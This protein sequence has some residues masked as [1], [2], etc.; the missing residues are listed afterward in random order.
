MPVVGD[1]GLGPERKRE[2][3]LQRI[4]PTYGGISG[5]YSG[6]T[7]TPTTASFLGDWRSVDAWM[8][9]ELPIAR[10]RS[11]QIERGN[12]YGQSFKASLTNNVLGASGIKARSNVTHSVAYGDPQSKN[13]APDAAANVIIADAR[14]R[15]EKQ[16]NCT[17]SKK[18]S[19]RELDQLILQRM[20]FDGETILRKRPGFANDFKF[21]WEVIDADYLDHWLNRIEPNGNV[22]RMGIE[23]DR[24]FG[25]PVAY[26]FLTRRPGD[27]LFGRYDPEQYKH[28]R[29]P[30]EEII[31]LFVTEYPGQSRGIP[32]IFSVLVKL[33]MQG[34]YEEAAITNA[35]IGAIKS[36]FFSK[37]YP[38]GYEGPPNG[39]P[40]GDDGI[41]VEYPQAGEW[42]ELPYG[43]KP[44]A[45]DPKYP[46]AEFGKFNEAMLLGI[47]S[48]LK[49][50]YAG[51]SGDYSQSNFSSSRMG[52]NEERE[53]WKILQSFLIEK[54]KEPEWDEWLYRSILSRQINLPLNKFDKFNEPKFTGRRWGYINPQQDLAA[55]Q[56]Q[57]A[58]GSTSITAI[59]EEGGGDRDELLAQIKQDKLD[60]G[61]LGIN[62]F[63]LPN[64]PLKPES[65]KELDTEKKPAPDNKPPPP[66]E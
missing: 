55:Q 4:A 35:R 61:A 5:T 14:Y 10:A 15:F 31:H 2:V 23:Q 29:V 66:E 36:G 27:Y 62:P 17:T 8:A 3:F 42:T 54:W 40:G 58:I 9:A 63:V 43:V 13:G 7:T 19:G 45:W 16:E 44:V 59:I 24:E 56:I 38:T 41:M 53:Y 50:S 30:A 46:D 25:F 34:A 11:R 64:T 1:I 21:A 60:F 52:V 57:L 28:V 49:I 32:W 20:A 47:S 26:W 65:E 6:S 33:Q 39:V 37:E 51:L 22:I 18:L 48:G 12:P